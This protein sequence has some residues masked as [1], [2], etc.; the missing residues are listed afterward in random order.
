MRDAFDVV[1]V[2]AGPNGL[3]AA[4]TCARAG[5]GVLLLEGRP[6]VGGGARSAELTLP[7][8][9][10]DVCS[11]I[12]PLALASPFLQALPLAEHGLSWSFPDCELAHP[13]DGGR[14]AVVDRRI[15]VTAA[16]LDG[17]GDAY[18]RLLAP[19]VRDAAALYEDALAPLGLPK[20]PLVLARFGLQAMRSTSALARGHFEQ[21]AA[22]ALFA[23]CGAHSFLPLGAPFTGAFSL[24]LAVAAHAVGWPC[25]R[26]GSQRI[27][28][29][30]AG[31]FA[32]LGGVT[33]TGRTVASMSDLPPA[34]AYLFDVFPHAL[35]R[36]AGERLPAGYRAAL[37]RYRHA[38]GVFKLDWALHA[39]IPWSAPG[40]R[41]AGTVHVGG[42]L[43]E[44]EASE[45]AVARGEHPE[46]PFVLVAQQSLADSSRAPVGSHTGW[47]YCHV[48]FGSTLDRTTAIEAQIER[49]APGFRDCILARHAMSSADYEA[50]NPNNVGGD[51]AGGAN[52]AVQLFARPVARRVPY[53]TPA[54]DVFLCSSAT[55]PGG[56][57]HGMCGYFAARVA[58][59]RVFGKSACLDAKPSGRAGA[60]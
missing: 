36:I 1:V 19:L 51:I 52:D 39:P 34:R 57:V 54:P 5:L 48:P 60:S 15:D 35:A 42:T 27:A 18:A 46:R 14:A 17:D 45:A 44:I 11:A 21:A 7:G 31:Y 8:F 25:A 55:P 58:L 22:R 24:I 12:H 49:F 41:G 23:G 13:L 40:A 6:T 9:V 20:H 30:L 37:L 4:I 26:G 16:T 2:G 47:A 10:H 32:S 33:R 59:R 43:E 56:G 29:A 3:A 50:Y 38:W 28:D 53:A